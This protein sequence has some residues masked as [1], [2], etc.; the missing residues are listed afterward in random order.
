MS[1]GISILFVLMMFFSG[2]SRG[3]TDLL[4]MLPT[5]AYWQ[6][7]Q[8]TPTLEQLQR[9]AGVDKAPANIDTQLKDLAADDFATR[10]KAKKELETMGPGIIPLLK[11]ATNAKDP[12]VAAVATELVTRFTQRAQERAI[13][14]LMAI[15][16]LGER[17]EQAALPLLKSL[18]DSR[19]LFVSDYAL[20]A[21]AAIEG[22]K[23][24]AVDRTKEFQRD[25]GL[26]PAKLSVVGQVRGISSQ[27]LTLAGLVD[28]VAEAPNPLAGM[29]PGQPAVAPVP[30][31]KK[32]MV[33]NATAQVLKVLEA[34]GN[35]RV[36]GL[37]LGLSDNLG[38]DGGSA[39]IIVRGK[40]DAANVQ[41]ML[42]P[43]IMGEAGPGNDR[44]KTWNDGAINVLEPDPESA[45]ILPSNDVLVLV[46]AGS[47]ADK[48]AALSAAVAALKSG[49]GTLADNKDLAT[50][51]QSVDT[52]LPAWAVIK[53]D[54]AMQK[55]LDVLAGFDTIT[56]EGK[57]TAEGIGF[58]FKGQGPDADK[59]K[60]S[61]DATSK[62]LQ[63]ALAEAQQQALQ[64]K[65]MQPVVDFMASMKVAA[66]GK[67]ATLSGEIKGSIIKA[68]VSQLGFLVSPLLEEPAGPAGAPG[69]G[70]PAAPAAQP[71]VLQPGAGGQ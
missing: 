25:V 45:L 43:L 5:D 63:T 13:R 36:D 66:E 10:D 35:I 23:L 18:T 57:P 39:T 7:K 65:A 11:P 41:A 17:K 34:A 58:T 4:D 15:R 32:K 54:A 29:M 40:Y 24:E 14:R 69:G 38:P 64:V 50:L 30:P 6:V 62:G 44:A 8:V 3:G 37:T 31:D 48:T 56:L 42:K 1:S 9:D 52:K 61:V 49:K 71:A 53:P 46:F 20:R 51:M 60:A 68:L 33:L 19:E 59:I 55:E 27:A 70:L 47:A 28:M 21:I 22:N 67:N 12:E 2:G 16:T 26:L